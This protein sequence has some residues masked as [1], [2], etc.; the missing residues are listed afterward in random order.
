MFSLNQIKK[1]TFW[2]GFDVIAQSLF[3]FI[4]SII[5]ARILVPEHFGIIAISNIFVALGISIADGGMVSALI[6]KDKISELEKNTAFWYSNFVGFLLIVLIWIFAE[7]LSIFFN[8]PILFDVLK[9]SS[10]SIIFNKISIVNV[11]M[12]ARNL[13]FK[14]RFFATF[15]SIILSG[16]TS[17]I[18]ANLGFGVWSLVVQVLLIDLIYSVSVLVLYKWYPRFSFNFNL[19]KEMFSYGRH[20]MFQ[21]ISKTIFEN[22]YHLVIGKNFS[23]A[24]LGYFHRSKRF[25]FIISNTPTLIANRASFPILS[26]AQNDKEVLLKM[27]KNFLT[28]SMI[29][30]L[31]LFIGLIITASNVIIVLIGDKWLPSVP[32]LRILCITGCFAPIHILACNLLNSQGKSLAA[33]SAELSRNMLILFTIILLIKTNIETLLIGELFATI[34]ST[35]ITTIL[36]K[37]V[38]KIEIKFIFNCI[39]KPLIASLTM[40]VSIY[41]IGSDLSSVLSLGLKVLIGSVVYISSLLILGE[42]TVKKYFNKILIKL[43]GN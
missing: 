37:K 18:M 11:S 4:F 7:R 35:I 41:W 39:K 30:I 10:F 31:P 21:L 15:V 12:I 29:I 8:E 23:L 38:L 22:I 34:M 28:L 2:A 36:L 32:F 20:V 19:F 9:W 14:K 24:E 1:G 17:I 43:Y 5:L 42:E 40:G 13:M 25:S 27:Y 3:Q 16:L 26:R 6:Q 33:F